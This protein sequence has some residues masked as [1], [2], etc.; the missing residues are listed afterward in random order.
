MPTPYIKKLHKEGKGSISKLE[1]KWKEAEELAKKQGKGSNYAYITSIF[2]NMIH[3]DLDLEAFVLLSDD[4][5][6]TDM[7]KEQQ[8]DYIELHPKSKYAEDAVKED[9]RTE[10]KQIQPKSKFRLDAAKSIRDNI[11][12]IKA[13]LKRTFPKLHESVE[14]LKKVRKGEEITPEDKEVLYE[15]G[16][17]VI[18]GAMYHM[19]VE[20]YSAHYI[21]DIGITSIRHAIEH[22]KNK[23]NDRREEL[24]SFIESVADGI[25]N[26]EPYKNPKVNRNTKQKIV[27]ALKGSKHHVLIVLDKTFPDI[28]PAT[29]G[30]AILAHGGKLDKEHKKAVV[31]LGRAALGIAIITLP[32]GIAAH[33]T[34][35]L[36]TAAIS[37]AIKTIGNSRESK[38]LVSHFV[39]ALNEGI[40]RAI[41]EDD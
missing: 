39:D 27:N 5:W 10:P 35:N 38:S 28:K 21:A 36:G 37:Y 7:T 31:N 19:H 14:V 12:K 40:E 20:A 29:K 4:N 32:G 26:S 13:R 9:S 22:F 41:V 8:K 18:H 2:K 3:A 34:A 6:F 30:L 1:K 25:E 33:M 16:G 11:P 17:K 24:D 23:K 15:L